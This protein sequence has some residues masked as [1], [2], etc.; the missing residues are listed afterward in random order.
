MVPSPGLKVIAGRC[1]I[2]VETV[3][4]L[5]TL[6][7]SDAVTVTLSLKVSKTTLWDLG[8]EQRGNNPYVI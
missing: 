2:S 5:L 3:G 7:L 1:I 8:N 6:K 4:S